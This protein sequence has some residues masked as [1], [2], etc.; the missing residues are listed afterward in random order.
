MG[1]EGKAAATNP[2][3]LF[4]AG[5][6]AC[7]HNAM[8]LVARRMKLQLEGTSVQANVG[9][10]AAGDGGF[11]LTVELVITLPGVER[12]QAEALVAATHG[13]CPYSKAT[14]GNIEVIATIA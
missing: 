9:I 14:R 1:G 12:E 3:Q 13:V 4:A 8:L 11:D 5:Y 6:S 10:G 2:E 7:F